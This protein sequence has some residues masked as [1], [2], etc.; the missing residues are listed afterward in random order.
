MADP[1]NCAICP[2]QSY[3]YGHHTYSNGDSYVEYRC[4]SKHKTLIPKEEINGNTIGKD[5]EGSN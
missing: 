2:A 4:T 1:V 3:L 5:I